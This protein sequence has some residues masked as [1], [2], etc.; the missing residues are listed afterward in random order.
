VH[1][2]DVVP[3]LPQYPFEHVGHTVQMNTDSM[4]AYYLHHGNQTLGYG[5]VPL[6]WSGTFQTTILYCVYYLLHLTYSS[7]FAAIPFIWIPGAVWSHSIRRYEWY[8]RNQ[9]TA[10]PSRYFVEEFETT[11]S[12]GTTTDDNFMDDDAW[13]NPPKVSV[14]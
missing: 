13:I 9:S 8:L 6:G 1:G 5:G 4:K 3:R 12:N 10:D 7:H 14:S 2:W 11:S